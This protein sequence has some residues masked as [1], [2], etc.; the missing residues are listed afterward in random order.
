MTM[1]AAQL[2]ETRAPSFEQVLSKSGAQTGALQPLTAR[3]ARSVVAS[4]CSPRSLLVGVKWRFVCGSPIERRI[5]RRCFLPK[6]S[7]TPGRPSCGA[8]TKEPKAGA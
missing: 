6:Q 7:A 3:D 4:Y 5:S 1:K 2:V 8:P